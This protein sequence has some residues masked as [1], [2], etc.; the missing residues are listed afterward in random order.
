[1][2]D[3][4]HDSWHPNE[5]T[6]WVN[7][8]T[9]RLCVDPVYHGSPQPRSPGRL[10]LDFL[11]IDDQWLGTQFL[12]TP[13]AE[14]RAINSLSLAQCHALCDWAFLQPRRF[15]I[16][17]RFTVN[18][19]AIIICSSAKRFAEI[20]ILPEKQVFIHNW[21]LVRSGREGQVMHDGWIRYGSG[22]IFGNTLL[23]RCGCGNSKIWL[24][25]ANHMFNHIGI[26]SNFQQYI[27]VRQVDFWFRISVPTS[28]P[29]RGFLFLCPA[30]DFR[31]RSFSFKTPDNPAYWS[32]DPSGVQRLSQADATALGFPRIWLFT[33]EISGRSWDANAYIAL[34]QFHR[35]KG[36]DPDSQEVARHLGYPAYQL[37]GEVKALFA[38]G[39]GEDYCEETEDRQRVH[40]EHDSEEFLKREP[41]VDETGEAES[42]DLGASH[43]CKF[44]ISAR[45][46]LICFLALLRVYEMVYVK[47]ENSKANTIDPRFA[48]AASEILRR[49]AEGTLVEVGPERDEL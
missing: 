48:A 29:P 7:P 6:Y 25:Q 46:A 38:Q 40:A 22:D 33:V 41:A 49:F 17:P 8:A 10:R 4:G 43:T 44:F 15:S 2:Y 3:A 36:F 23:L 45:L 27:F 18:L 26:T 30:K 12:D 28:N 24:S 21:S 14:T 47:C 1:M 34:R 31:T 16:S 13:D 20:A 19:G 11:G 37:A 42:D 32:L 5:H 39:N 35:A 9:G